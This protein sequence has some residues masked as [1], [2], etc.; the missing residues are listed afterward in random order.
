MLSKT[1]YI[2]Y[3]HSNQ[4]GL[5]WTGHGPV[6]VLVSIR[7]GRTNSNDGALTQVTLKLNPILS[8]T[9]SKVQRLLVPRE[10]QIQSSNFHYINHTKFQ[11]FSCGISSTS[12]TKFFIIQV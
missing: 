9:P 4:I 8:R 10:I 7:A 6:L 3:P 11:G 5:E 12:P 1:I 2:N